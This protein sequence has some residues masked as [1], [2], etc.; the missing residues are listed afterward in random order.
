MKF[1]FY[2]EVIKGNV[3]YEE[4]CNWVDDRESES[5]SEGYDEGY[6]NGYNDGVNLILEMNN[7]LS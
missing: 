4:F 7:D 6:N 3:S 1:E 5:Y 2:S